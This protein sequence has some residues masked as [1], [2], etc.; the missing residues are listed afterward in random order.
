VI[1]WM[2]LKGFISFDFSGLFRIVTISL[3]VLF[4]LS[5][6]QDIFKGVLD[7]TQHVLSWDW[8]HQEGNKLL[9]KKI[10]AP[11]R[12]LGATLDQANNTFDA[13]LNNVVSNYQLPA[14][15]GKI[16]IGKTGPEWRNC[17]KSQ[18]CSTEDLSTVV[19]PNHTPCGD[20][21]ICQ[22]QKV[23][24]SFGPTS[25]ASGNTFKTYLCDWD[26]LPDS[27]CVK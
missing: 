18:I 8:V 13:C 25:N 22:N 2:I 21:E 3:L 23:P 27:M 20:A 19:I 10:A 15:T 5:V 24:N 16:C 14:N 7:R 1:G 4:L 26:M 11:A 17:M 9:A 12:G 6:G